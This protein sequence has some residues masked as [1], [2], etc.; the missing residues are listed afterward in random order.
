MSDEVFRVGER[1]HEKAV[2]VLEAAGKADGYTADEYEAALLE[3]RASVVEERAIER[4]ARKL[5][6]DPRAAAM[7]EAYGLEREDLEQLIAEE[8]AKADQYGDPQLEQLL[9][10]ERQRQR[11]ALDLYARADL[12]KRGIEKPSADDY[13]AALGRAEIAL[14]WRYR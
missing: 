9:A 12:R 14:G 3:A 7:A 10:D 11:Y 4:L 1:L 8:R 2:Q 13:A 6:F 5:G